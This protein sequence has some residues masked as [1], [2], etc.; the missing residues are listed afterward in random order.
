[1]N[2][3]NFIFKTRKQ[4]EGKTYVEEQE[5][6]DILEKIFSVPTL[7]ST[8]QSKVSALQKDVQSLNIQPK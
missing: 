7:I 8:I 2:S 3:P 1:M 4:I 5:V 6:L